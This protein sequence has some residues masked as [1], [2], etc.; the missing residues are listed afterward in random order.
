LSSIK[1]SYLSTHGS[2]Q[3]S[4]INRASRA[5]DQSI[6]MKSRPKSIY[7]LYVLCYGAIIISLICQVVIKIVLDNTTSDLWHKRVLLNNAQYRTYFMTRIQITA[8][9][10]TQQ[11]SGAVTP[12]QL[13][14]AATQLKG[15]VVNMNAI[16]VNLTRANEAI[17]DGG[18]YLNQ[19]ISNAM[20]T[21][22]IQ[23]TDFALQPLDQN[24]TSFETVNLV[25]NAMQRLN[26]LTN[27]SSTEG[28]NIFHY[29]VINTLN[30]FL[31]N[32][33]EITALFLDSVERQK[34]VLEDITLLF[35]IVSPIWLFITVQVLGMIIWKQYKIEKGL[36]LEFIGLH[37]PSVNDMY[38]IIKEFKEKL[39][40]E[41]NLEEGFS[42]DYLCKLKDMPT[43]GPEQVN[44]HAKHGRTVEYTKIKDRYYD[45]ILK[46]TLFCLIVS[47]VI[48]G[49]Y[50]YISTTTKRIYRMQDQLQFA[51]QLSSNATLAYVSCVEVFVSNNTNQV[52]HRDPL[53]MLKTGIDHLQTIQ[54]NIV[55]KFKR[56]DG[57][58]SDD[59][60]IVL[61]R[62]SSCTKLSGQPKDL[63]NSLLNASLPAN[64]VDNI[65]H[66]REGLIGKLN[67]YEKV[68]KSSQAVLNAAAI[69][70]IKTVLAQWSV[71][72]A[73]G[74]V[75]NEII[76]EQLKVFID[77]SSHNCS[78]I[79]VAFC[80]SFLVVGIQIWFQILSKVSQVN[81]QLKKVL[82][83]F[84]P[85]L[86]LSNKTLEKF[87][88][89]TSHNIFKFKV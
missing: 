67:D 37:E 35:V 17:Y 34:R 6:S 12:E 52:A 75:L 85:N 88:N 39:I 32:N 31:A 80:L 45:Y 19:A 79:L 54:D 14:L 25:Q 83:V 59:V 55:E 73:S 71:A 62:N 2:S 1:K 78:I 66:F 60:E 58:Y 36:L 41:E 16:M 23:V 44:S 84:P 15:N 8:R 9:G 64:L 18:K 72:A 77:Q 89:E 38:E 4:Q 42:A 82:S 65:I 50:F 40:T 47:A 13:G 86:I 27:V 81:N 61:F 5:F 3:T 48:V 30:D 46:V 68:E 57:G 53:D 69:P 74:N 24:F 63:C 49:S 56:F 87:M 29:L 43:G 70:N 10:G 22:N 28:Y 51:N 33:A 7:Y 21:R 20:Y 76:T 11:F 26:N